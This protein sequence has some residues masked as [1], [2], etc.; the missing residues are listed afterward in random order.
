MQN[1]KI[2]RVA[3]QWYASATTPLIT[4]NAGLVATG[5]T[6]QEASD[7]LTAKYNELLSSSN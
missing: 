6:P 7:N 5:K 4:N 2:Q 1:L 3:G